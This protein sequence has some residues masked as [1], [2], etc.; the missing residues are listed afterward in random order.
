[1]RKRDEMKAGIRKD[2]AARDPA[3]FGVRADVNEKHIAHGPERLLWPNAKAQ[4]PGGRDGLDDSKN[5]NGRPVCCSDLFGVF[6]LRQFLWPGL[7]HI[8]KKALLT[9]SERA[10]VD[11]GLG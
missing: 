11:A 10:V 4:Q 3:V 9:G 6:V 1:M 5:Q 8:V 7:P 2:R